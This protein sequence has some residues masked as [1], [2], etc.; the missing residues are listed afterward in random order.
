MEKWRGDVWNV[1]EY[2]KDEDLCKDDEESREIPWGHLVRESRTDVDC[3]MIAVEYAGGSDYGGSDDVTKVNYRFLEEEYK[4]D[5][6]FYFVYGGYGSYG[7][8]VVVPM[9]DGVVYVPEDVW[10]DVI[11]PLERYPLLDEDASSMMAVEEEGEQ[12]EGWIKGDFL[13]ALGKL[14]GDDRTMEG[15]EE[16]WER[17]EER[18]ED[19][20]AWELYGRGKEKANVYFYCEEG[21]AWYVDVERCAGAIGWRD[22]VECV[23]MGKR[24]RQLVRLWELAMEVHGSGVDGRWRVVETRRRVGVGNEYHLMSKDGYYVGWIPFTVWIEKGTGKWDISYHGTAGRYV[25]RVRDY[26]E[27]MIADVIGG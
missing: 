6:R 18:I 3:A 11:E 22:L 25:E 19:R 13:R 8:F 23:R 27:D 24:D 20:E 5:N 10:E 21:S 7:V 17:I 2:W 12:W 1:S 4:N 14:F 9:M 15:F 16:L 26:L